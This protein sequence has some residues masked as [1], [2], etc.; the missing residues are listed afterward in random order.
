MDS[1]ADLY[2][3]DL[4]G[5][6]PLIH[7]A[8][9][10]YGA[11]VETLVIRRL[12][13]DPFPSQDP[14]LIA[15][16]SQDPGSTIFGL[17]AGLMGVGMSLCGGLLLMCPCFCILRRQSQSKV[18]YHVTEDDKETEEFLDELYE[19]VLATKGQQEMVCAQFE[20]IPAASLKDIHR[21]RH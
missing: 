15:K 10:G 19:F 7:A 12:E 14:A 13:P 16:A 4:A 8:A 6:N 18:P 5:W 9:R 11:L 2:A 3:Q 17:P 21:P 20:N 1:G